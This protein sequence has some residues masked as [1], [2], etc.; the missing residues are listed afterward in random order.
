VLALSLHGR[1]QAVGG[2]DLY[3]ADP[4]GMTAVDVY[5]ARSVGQLVSDHLDMAADWSVWTPSELP[6][7]SDTP[8]A[9][10]RGRLWMAVGMLMLA[11]EAPAPDKLAVLRS[12]AYA[13]GRTADDVA[14]DLVER[15]LQPDQLREGAGSD[16]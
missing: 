11:L 3:F 5:E 10:R 16:R 2:M 1:L 6:A 12:Y 4:G 13:A 14:I 15:R 8:D 9:Q 7:W